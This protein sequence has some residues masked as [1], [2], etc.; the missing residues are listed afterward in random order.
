[1]TSQHDPHVIHV[2]GSV[3]SSRAPAGTSAQRLEASLDVHHPTS[4]VEL[5]EGYGVC[6]RCGGSGRV[7][8]TG[9]RAGRS[10]DCPRCG[11]TGAKGGTR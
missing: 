3:G 11:G 6:G 5:L 2:T 7:T 1:M 4:E 10:V 9:E 8:G